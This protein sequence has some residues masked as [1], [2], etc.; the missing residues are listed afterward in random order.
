[1]RT[2]SYADVRA[3]TSQYEQTIEQKNAELENLRHTTGSRGEVGDASKRCKLLEKQLAAANS[4]KRVACME[5][6]DLQAKLRK[7]QALLKCRKEEVVKVK[8]SLEE[9]NMGRSSTIAALKMTIETL[10]QE[11]DQLSSELAEQAMRQ[12][13]E[14][15]STG[16]ACECNRS[17]AACETTR[18]ER[19]SQACQVC[20]LQSALSPS[21]GDAE[22]PHSLATLL[23]EKTRECD[24][25]RGALEDLS[26]MQRDALAILEV[27]KNQLSTE[28][29]RRRMA[30]DDVE[31]LSVQLR[32]LQQRCSDQTAAERAMG[33]KIRLLGEE[34]QK[35]L[36]EKAQIERDRD[37]WEEQLRQYEAD[38][39]QLSAT[40]NHSNRQLSTLAN[41]NEN[42]R[43]EMQQ[44]CEREAQALYAVKAKDMEVQEILCAYQKSAQE[45]ESLMESQRFLERELDNVRAG[46]ASKEETVAYLQE[47]LRSMHLREQQLT[48]DLQSLEYE[49]ENHHQRLARGDH[50]AA[51]LDAKCAELA[52]L[53]HTKER[54]IEELH[55]S[56]SELSKQVIVKE[57]E[58]LLLRQ[59]CD[60]LLADMALLRASFSNEKA[61]VQELEAS[62]ARLVARE[63]L[64]LSD[65]ADRRE[66]A[67]VLEDERA[68]LKAVIDENE[69][70]A[71]SCEQL[72]ESNKVLECKV[73]ELEKSLQESIEAKERLHRIVL[74]QNKAL[75]R[76]SE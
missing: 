29:E 65:A 52:Q 11:R 25:L 1:M 12:R 57:N 34:R 72:A 4:E 39:A 36:V 42:L 10:S 26:A 49:N 23:E 53:L 62:N 66:Q 69:R 38:V 63:V 3:L 59:R 21:G 44:L 30:V 33:D 20:T 27:T 37:H 31:N 24:Q 50:E 60:T 48:L 73:A 13:V 75:S 67:R 18:I 43:A 40:K 7:L 58:S 8:G 76:L 22:A 47:Q 70:I 28:A 32:A 54:C 15:T 68:T 61:K 56:L 14:R 16:T 9:S 71:A 64:S 19:I 17:E 45:N 55:Q 74:D 46:L 2:K 6:A 5:R 51:E 41:E 35:L